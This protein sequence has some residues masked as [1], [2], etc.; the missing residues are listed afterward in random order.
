[1]LTRP[2]SLLAYINDA[3]GLRLPQGHFIDG[4]FRRSARWTLHAK[5]GSRTRREFRRF[6]PRRR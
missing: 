6:R 3:G 4:E 5:R 1:M 2:D